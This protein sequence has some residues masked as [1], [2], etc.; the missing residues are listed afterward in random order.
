[1][2]RE[3]LPSEV[4]EQPEIREQFDLLG[5]QSARMQRLVDDLLEYAR[6]GAGVD[7]HEPVE[8]GATVHMVAEILQPPAGFEIVTEGELPVA[9]LI[10]PN[11]ELILRNLIGNA[12]KH[13][14]RGE[15]R[16]VVRGLGWKDGR[17]CFE[18]EDDGPGIPDS[19]KARIFRAFERGSAGGHQVEGTGIGLAAVQRAVDA[20][21]GEVGLRDA[22]PG[23]GA[24]F[25]VTLG[26]PWLDAKEAA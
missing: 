21:G 10:R 2:L 20:H 6:A 26:Q 24:I 3:D 7:V 13:H 4:T 5:Q 23:R 22:Q 25:T 11:V 12:F 8:L 1:M 17:F 14:D 18:V 15:G 16:I 9:D 19:A